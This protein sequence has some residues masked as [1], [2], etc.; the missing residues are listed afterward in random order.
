LD[1][2]AALIFAP[3]GAETS[4]IPLNLT[5]QR[6]LGTLVPYGAIDPFLHW[7][8]DLHNSGRFSDAGLGAVASE[9]PLL[10]LAVGN[11]PIATGHQAKPVTSVH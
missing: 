5:G 10:G 2:C 3:G 4:P 9:L 1:K 6:A 11:V 8:A 7:F